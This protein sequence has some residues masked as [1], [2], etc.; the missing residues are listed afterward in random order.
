MYAF[1]KYDLY[2]YLLGCEV[3]SG[4]NNDGRVILK[5]YGGMSVQPVFLVAAEEGAAILAGL[6]VRETNN[7]LAKAQL[8][9][10]E[11]MALRA[12]L[13]APLIAAL[14]PH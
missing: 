9:Q 2:P 3:L 14:P 10:R 4:P 12:I 1:W 6:E 7:A 5:G 13:P 11:L 8:D